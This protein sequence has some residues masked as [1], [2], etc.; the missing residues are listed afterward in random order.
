[1]QDSWSLESNHDRRRDDTLLITL[2]TLT[3]QPQPS[4]NLAHPVL[5]ANNNRN[6]PTQLTVTIADDPSILPLQSSE[7]GKILSTSR[8]TMKFDV[9]AMEDILLWTALEDTSLMNKSERQGRFVLIQTQSIFAATGT[10][11][12]NPSHSRRPRF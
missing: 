6:T 8:M 12:S 7:Q 5:E 1:M 10:S 11:C 9:T 2:Y 4:F 3:P